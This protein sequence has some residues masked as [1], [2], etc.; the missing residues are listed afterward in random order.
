MQL[1]VCCVLQVMAHVKAK[2]HQQTAL[3][4]ELKVTR[5]CQSC[6]WLS[7]ACFT[8]LDVVSHRHVR[9]A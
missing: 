1:K 4:A 5:S 6:S 9:T 2:L 7:K 3:H 8:R